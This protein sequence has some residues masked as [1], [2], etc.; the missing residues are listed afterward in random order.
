MVVCGGGGEWWWC[1]MVVMVVCGGGGEW[2][3]HLLTYLLAT[4]V[5]TSIR[6]R[7]DLNFASEANLLPYKNGMP[8]RF[9]PN[10]RMSVPET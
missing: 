10:I 3:R 9:F 2:R 6:T 5:A 7:P 8:A 4:S 1:V